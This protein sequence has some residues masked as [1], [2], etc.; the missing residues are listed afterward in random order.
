M[1]SRDRMKLTEDDI[2]EFDDD[3]YIIA[4]CSTDN[5]K[6]LKKQ[7]LENQEK[8][9]LYDTLDDAEGKAFIE[10]V[11]RN[12]QIVERLRERLKDY[13]DLED[14]TPECGYATISKSQQ[15]HTKSILQ[16]ILSDAKG[17]GEQK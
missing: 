5:S 7:I 14:F 9:D 12:Q 6:L 10:C 11:V 4:V 3:D 15:L 17:I 13:D 1:E 8:A 2:R 16:S